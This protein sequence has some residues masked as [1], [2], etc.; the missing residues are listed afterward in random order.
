MNEIRVLRHTRKSVRTGYDVR[1]R[2]KNERGEVEEH[3]TGKAETNA[4]TSAGVGTICVYMRPSR[5]LGII[6]PLPAGFLLSTPFP[7]L[8]R[9]SLRLPFPRFSIPRLRHR[10]A[11]VPHVRAV[12]ALSSRNYFAYMPLPFS[13]SSVI[14]PTLAHYPFPLRGTITRPSV[15]YTFVGGPAMWRPVIYFSSNCNF[16]NTYCP[17]DKCASLFLTR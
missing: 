12:Y 1:G 16:S 3:E 8:A 11:I 7:S 5:P 14:P 17:L 6:Y 15:K 10:S 2:K 9:Q 13:L 4:E